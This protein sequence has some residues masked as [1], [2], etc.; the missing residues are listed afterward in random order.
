MRRQRAFLAVAELRVV[1]AVSHL[2]N[3]FGKRYFHEHQEESLGG[4]AP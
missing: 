4:A 1:S 2:E 3:E